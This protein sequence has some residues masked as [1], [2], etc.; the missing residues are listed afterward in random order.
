MHR[1]MRVRET[2]Y[3]HSPYIAEFYNTI[4]NLPFIII[5]ILRLCQDDVWNSYEMTILYTLYIFFGIC[6]GIHHSIIHKK[7]IIIDYIPIVITSVYF[8]FNYHWF[9]YISYVSYFKLL[10]A[11]SSLIIDHTLRLIPI[12]H[13]HCVW[14]LLAALGID[15]AYHDIVVVV[16][17]V[18]MS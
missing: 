15:S 14:H 16:C 17:S 18:G 9:S 8:L 1:F 11:F 10:L 3:S 4:T 13:G 6:S 2:P 12:P 5:G 7:S